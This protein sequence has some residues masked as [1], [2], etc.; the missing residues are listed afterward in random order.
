MNSLAYNQPNYV[1]VW[2]V[3]SWSIWYKTHRWLIGISPSL[4]LYGILYETNQSVIQPIDGISPVLNL[5]AKLLPRAEHQ[6]C[7]KLAAKSMCHKHNEAMWMTAP[8]CTLAPKCINPG[9]QNP[10][11]RLDAGEHYQ[12]AFCHPVL[13]ADMRQYDPLLERNILHFWPWLY[14]NSPTF[15]F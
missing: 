14:W 10:S 13:L 12:K 1:Y 7:F 15:R 2:Y 9:K 6:T 4:N 5:A 3:T 8:G 11:R